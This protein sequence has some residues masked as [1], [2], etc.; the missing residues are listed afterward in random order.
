MSGFFSQPIRRVLIGGFLLVALVPLVFLGVKLYKLAWEQA[1]RE[2]TEKHQLLAQ[3]LAQWR[4]LAPA[5]AGNATLRRVLILDPPSDTA[6]KQA[7]TIYH[8]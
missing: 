6:E 4:K 5:L 2:I 8:I 1:W 3:N 7:A